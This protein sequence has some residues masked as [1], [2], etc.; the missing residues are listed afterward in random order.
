MQGLHRQKVRSK[1]GRDSDQWR[2]SSPKVSGQVLADIPGHFEHIQAR[3]G[4]DRLQGR[5]RLDRAAIVEPVLLDIN[6]DLLGDLSARELLRTEIA[7]NASLSCFGAKMPTPFF[8]MAAAF[9]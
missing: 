9:F 1:S 2:I 5:I 3:N 7:A 8:F 4:H 6:P